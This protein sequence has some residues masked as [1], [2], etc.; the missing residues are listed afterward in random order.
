MIAHSGRA[1]PRSAVPKPSRLA[2]ARFGMPHLPCGVEAMA[3][4]ILATPDRRDFERLER[5]RGADEPAGEI[6]PG[7]VDLV[8]A[9]VVLAF[10]LDAGADLGAVV[11]HGRAG[12]FRR[13]RTRRGC[14][15]RC[16]PR[17]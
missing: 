1:S 2:A 16:R 7:F 17:P 6:D 4:D 5:D 15:V 3:L 11:E 9:A 10:E 12:G 8:A 14:C 13:R